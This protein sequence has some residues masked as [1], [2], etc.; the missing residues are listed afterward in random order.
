MSQEDYKT[1]DEVLKDLEDQGIPVG[2]WQNREP[3]G[4]AEAFTIPS[5]EKLAEGLS[6]LQGL[7]E[8]EK[9]KDQAQIAELNM[10][11]NRMR[12]GGGR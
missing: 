11:L 4:D 3:S 5:F 12:H 8:T 6:K 9:G 7:L 1:V 10:K 2:S